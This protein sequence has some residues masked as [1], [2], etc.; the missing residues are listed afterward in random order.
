MHHT[1]PP[2]FELY[3]VVIR[4]TT[5]YLNKR[6]LVAWLRVKKR[7]SPFLRS[8]VFAF[9]YVNSSKQKL[10]V[11]ALHARSTI[12]GKCSRGI[13]SE[14]NDLDTCA[15]GLLISFGKYAFV[16][17]QLSLITFYLKYIIAASSSYSKEH[18]EHIYVQY[19]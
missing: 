19:E 13:N 8:L 2:H 10:P 3:A 17:F 6:C 18:T 5:N 11:T 4:L 9:S 15:R 14:V 1:G 7:I 12:R 16:A